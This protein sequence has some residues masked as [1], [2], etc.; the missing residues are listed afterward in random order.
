MRQVSTIGSVRNAVKRNCSTDKLHHKDTKDTKFE[1]YVVSERNR[2]QSQA[3]E[4]FRTFVSF[5]SLWCNSIF[6]TLRLCVRFFGFEGSGAALNGGRSGY[7][8]DDDENDW[9]HRDRFTDLAHHPE[10]GRDNL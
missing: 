2:D 5:V 6:E 9:L 7:F 3:K 4:V 10:I 1:E 8:E